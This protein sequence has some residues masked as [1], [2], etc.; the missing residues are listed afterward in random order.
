MELLQLRYFKSAALTENFSRTAAQYMVPPSAVS[1]SIHK[2]EMELGTV[3]FERKANRVRLNEK[4]RLYFQ[5]VQQALD[6]LDGG[7]ELIQDLSGQMCGEIRLMV[8]TNRRIVTQAISRFKAENPGVSFAIS[9]TPV[10]GCDAFDL[11]VSDSPPNTGTLS[12]TLLLSEEILLAVAACHPLAEQESVNAATL[13]GERFISTT[14]ENSMYRITTAICRENGFAPDISIQCD[15]P[16]CARKYVEMG[17]GISFVPSVSW[18]GQFSSQ[19]R[20]LRL[21]PGTYTRDTYLYRT[22]DKYLSAAAKLFMD[23]L[24]DSFRSTTPSKEE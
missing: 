13:R 9:H 1:Q 16:Y 12:R 17:L 15:D 14:P 6:A 23:D 3:L 24:F 4:G 19:V 18:Q 22:Q 21:L 8:Q 7:R 5:V 2:L 10:S 20:L 11:I